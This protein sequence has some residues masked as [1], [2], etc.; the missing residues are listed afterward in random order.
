MLRTGTRR[1]IRWSGTALPALVALCVAV[2]GF[3]LPAAAQARSAVTLNAVAAK[4]KPTSLVTFSGRAGARAGARVTIQ[5]L[6]GGSWRTIAAGRTGRR[7]KFALTWMTPSR[8]SRVVVRATLGNLV[9]ASRRF[10]VRAP[11]KGAPKVVVSPK[12]RVI[13]ASVVKSVPAPGRSG[14]L[15]YAGGN[16][17]AVGQI[18]VIGQGRDTPNGFLGRVTAVHQSGGQTVVSTA[19]ATLLQA[20][21]TGS[22][23][24]VTPTVTAS[25]A[26]IA[27]G[28]ITCENDSGI[29]ITHDVTFGAGLDLEAQWSGL[30]LQSASL[31]ASAS[32]NASVQAAITLAGSCSLE[33]RALLSIK[34]PSFD[35]FVGPVP[36]V[37]TSNLTV[38]FDASASAQA[39]LSTDANAGFSASAGVSWTRGVGFKGIRSFVPHYGFDPPSLS[40]SADVQANVTPTVDV[41]FYGLAGPQVA[42]QTG[43]D[44]S[45]DTT[46]NPWWAL[47]IPVNLTASI[48]IPP[49][50]LTSPALTL[51]SHSFPL[52]NAGGPFGTVYHPPPP[53]HNVATPSTSLA[54]GYDQSCAL[55]SSGAVA[56]WGANSQGELGNTT[57]N[58]SN[59]PVAVSGITDAAGI[60]ADNYHTCALRVG[61]GVLC[62]GSNGSG[63]FGN[64]SPGG[65]SSSPVAVTGISNATAIAAGAT[66]SCAVLS[67][68]TVNCWGANDQNQLGEGDNDPSPVPIAVSGISSATAIASGTFHTCALLSNGTVSCWGNNSDGSLGDGNENPTAVPVAVSGLSN[69]I[70]IAAG[71]NHSC[72]LL[73][74]GTVWCWGQNGH[75]QLG[76]GMNNPSSVPVQVSGITNATTIAAGWA[77][78]C[79]RLSTG[80]VSC[81]GYNN[82]GQLGNGT[83]GASTGTGTDSNN[84]VPATGIS[85][86]TATTGGAEHSCAL[87]T[88]GGLDC[89]G[90]GVDGE[91]GNGANAIASTPVT[92]TGF[93]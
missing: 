51:Y 41:L 58:P 46:Q 81:W 45:A 59:T 66:H 83:A 33:K 72:A 78:T 24:L 38:Y 85:T 17:V 9:S 42:L 82:Y 54:A 23:H 92:V 12:T 63:E 67:D 5:R 29:S 47:T 1:G 62:W 91:L 22:M 34:G 71:T 39:Q 4:K 68:G 89:W 37:M 80:A 35:G 16:D 10:R 74:N 40:A 57:H 55:R 36:I 60:V 18:L 52:A 13:S 28:T 15:T 20:V 48:A 56:C 7:G 75:G 50:D 90:Y 64:G 70:A 86:A 87:L 76:N 53:V 11:A 6:I 88:T 25:R 31:T 19:P 43:I 65:N 69:V 21:P 8:A 77:H 14:T 32:F 44:F 73:S 26:H 3:V 61:G 2:T 93:P 27:K 49:L 30:K 84:P 79:A